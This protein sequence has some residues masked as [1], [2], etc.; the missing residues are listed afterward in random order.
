MAFCGYCGTVEIAWAPSS[1]VGRAEGRW[2]A[3]E[4]RRGPDGGVLRAPHR[5]GTRV[6]YRPVPNT[7]RPHYPH[8]HHGGLAG[9][10]AE[11]ECAVWN[12]RAAA[13]AITA[14]ASRA[15][16]RTRPDAAA[17]LVDSAAAL[18][19]R[20]RTPVSPSTAPVV[21]APVEAAAAPAGARPELLPEPEALLSHDQLAAWRRADAAMRCDTVDPATGT[22]A[23]SR[24]LL[25]GRP[26]TG[27]TEAPWL[28]AK[29]LGWT[30]VYQM[31]T[32]ETPGTDLTG[33][34]VVQGGDT[35]WSD[36]SLGRAIRASHAGPVVYVLDEIGR[37]SQDAMS[38]CLLALANPESLRLPLR[39]GEVLSPRGEHWR[40][41]ACTNSEPRELD[42][43]LRDRLHIAVHLDAPSPG[44]VRSMTRLETR[45]AACS[46]STEYSIRA[47]LTYDRLCAA[48]WRT[49]AAARLV[50]EPATA[51]SW[52]DAMR[53]EAGPRA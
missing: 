40:V 28:I 45:R 27:K 20:R 39:T 11:H 44:L 6:V 10:R 23:L 29:E 24:V 38:A 4:A 53:L 51:Q 5:D 41:V 47:L 13:E 19:G 8:A 18:L 37:A 52:I 3:C 36:G 32:E 22:L 30:H 16:W 46:M 12:P 35:A 42:P 33:H 2:V 21:A 14:R 48:G 34:L 43:A 25:H 31:L 1:S 9:E 15:G 26:G 17:P 49:D 50:W 7:D